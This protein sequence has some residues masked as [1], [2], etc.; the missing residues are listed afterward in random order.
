MK[1]LPRPISGQFSATAK[2]LHWGV[3]FFLLSVI[4]VAW[5]FAFKAPSDRAE[6]I[7]AHVSIGLIVVALTLIRLAWRKAAPPPPTPATAPAW[8]HKGAI[9]GHWL[10]YA[11]ILFQGVIGIWMAALSPVDIRFFNTWDI[12]ALAP[13]SAG[14]LVYLRQIHFAGASLL[15]ITLIGHVAAALW[16]H[17]V[18][19]D[20]V[21]IRMLPFSVLWQRV[22]APMRNRAWR[23]PSH[24]GQNWPTGRRR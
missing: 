17:F 9:L 1:R 15:V 6:A 14:S 7:P 3:A 12:S 8:M 5:G 16:H 13:D 22:T 4:S 20:D 2:W 23:F 21:L 19:R 11:L 24:S 18:L 10:L